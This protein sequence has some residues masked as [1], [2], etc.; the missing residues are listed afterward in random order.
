LI[1]PRDDGEKNEGETRHYQA[2]K[3]ARTAPSPQNVRRTA[4]SWTLSCP[5][6][7][8]A[9]HMHWEKKGA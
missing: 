9:S 1:P 8:D 5:I 4:T 6:P 3:N 7:E 2:T